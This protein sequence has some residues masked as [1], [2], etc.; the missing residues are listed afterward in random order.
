MTAIFFT[1]DVVLKSY[2]LIHNSSMDAE[3]PEFGHGAFGQNKT[4]YFL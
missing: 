1:V 3:G 4:I 2:S